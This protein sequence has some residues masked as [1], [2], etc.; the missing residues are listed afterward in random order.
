MPNVARLVILAALAW[1][2]M[3]CAP[4]QGA[5]APQS[6]A[7][8]PSAASASPNGTAPDY[9]LG[10]GDNLRISVFGEESLTGQFTV[11]GNGN[12]SF[13][14]IGDVQAAG[15][16]VEQLRVEI[17]SALADGYIREPKVSAEVITFRPYY[18]LGEVEK[19][20]QYPYSSGISVM[21]AIATAGG[22]TYRA[23]EHD[24][25][26]K[27]ANETVEHKV[28]LNDTLELSPGDTL[29]VGERYF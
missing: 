23:N 7:S 15:K 13:P 24:V 18:I 12:V 26:I 1:G 4:A 8:E 22:F 10:A 2:L 16:T 14:L 19:P 11:A 25:F 17:A 27:R 3:I 21:N 9:I 29:R 28:H 5:A 6:G 20:G